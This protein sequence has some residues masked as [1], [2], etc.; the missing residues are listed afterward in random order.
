MNKYMIPLGLWLGFHIFCNAFK[1]L[2]SR[3]FSSFC[4]LLTLVN[5]NYDTTSIFICGIEPVLVRGSGAIES[6]VT[7]PAMRA[8]DAVPQMKKAQQMASVMV[9]EAPY[10]NIV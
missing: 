10:L 1:N 8:A 5:G 9:Y 4:R 2:A 6:I 3:A 7:V